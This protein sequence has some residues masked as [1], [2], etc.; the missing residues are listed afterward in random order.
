MRRR[1]EAYLDHGYGSY[2]LQN[3][4][5]AEMV[6]NALLFHDHAKYRLIAWA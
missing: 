5:I 2:F 6:Q 4:G 3:P 1:V